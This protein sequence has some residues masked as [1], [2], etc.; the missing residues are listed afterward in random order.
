MLSDKD[1]KVVTSILGDDFFEA[2]DKS[3]IG[4]GLVKL[5]TR[6]SLD[7]EE[8]RISLQI[9][10]RTI[11]SYLFANLTYR[12]VNDVIDLDLPFAINAKLHLNKKGPDNYNGEVIQDGKVLYEIKHRSIPGIGLILLTTFELYNLSLLDE[13]KQQLP[14]EPQEESRVDK[15]Q[16]MI[17][18]R[19][20][21]HRLI[22]D[23]VD[24]RMSEREAINRLIKEKLHSHIM[25]ASYQ[26]KEEEPMEETK[27]SK[28]RE[29]LESREKKRDES[30]ELDKNE[31]SCPDCGT[32]LHKN[33]DKVIKLCICYG[34][35]MN[36]EIKINKQEDD[37][38]KL[39]FPKSFDIDNI[40]MLLEALKQK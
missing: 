17:D 5:S 39:K 9:V 1:K 6:T 26:T 21:M 14:P 4:G 12:P 31:I 37:K 16:D 8:I 20:C 27:K 2:L 15:L 34:D 7:P 29:F 3:E 22:Q 25:Q 11:L 30:F 36:K 13:I 18:D 24:K 19:L 28:L 38:V 32:T 10:P 40:E 35:H 33:E 23:V